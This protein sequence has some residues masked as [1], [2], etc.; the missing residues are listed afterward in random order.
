LS[1]PT[2]GIAN[3]WDEMVRTVAFV[4]AGPTTIYTLCAFVDETTAPARVTIFE[5]QPRA[6][7]G[8][9]YRPERSRDA[10]EYRQ[11]RNP[12][13]RGGAD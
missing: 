5:A 12:S 11:H 8:T 9:P 1:R 3:A 4:G 6:A 10:V 13:N 2:D 7:L